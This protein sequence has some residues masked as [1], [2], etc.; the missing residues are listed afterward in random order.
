MAK[1]LCGRRDNDTRAP[2]LLRLYR[3]FAAEAAASG[4][5]APSRTITHGSIRAVPP[6]DIYLSP[7]IETP[8]ST[9]PYGEHV[10]Y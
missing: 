10:L 6:S 3:T 8:T 1:N 4:V 7:V 5:V 9:K 2:G